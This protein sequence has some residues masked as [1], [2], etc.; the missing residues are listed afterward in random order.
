MHLLD[1]INCIQP[2]LGGVVPLS[3]VEV[4]MRSAGGA[5]TSQASQLD[6][7]P[8]SEAHI[9]LPAKTVK[10]VPS[11]KRLNFKEGMH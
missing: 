1:R 6:E 2:N 5:D 10:T 9:Q 3:L 8:K 4:S 7:T 11:R